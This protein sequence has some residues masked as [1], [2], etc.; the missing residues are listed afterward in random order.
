VADTGGRRG[1]V[2]RDKA[3]GTF[4]VVVDVSEVGAATRKQIKRRGFATEREAHRALTRLLTELDAGSYV[5]PDLK[6]TLRDYVENTWLPALAVRNRRPS[7]IESYKRNLRVHVFP[8]LGLR[9]LSRI[10]TPDL[11][12][13]Y[14][15]LLAGASGRRPLSPRTVRYIHTILHG[16]FQH[17][18]LKGNL[19]V[20]PCQRA[21]APEPKACRSREMKTWTAE[22]LRH[23]L[24]TLEGDRFRA[25]LLLLATTGMRRGEALGL[26]WS[27]LRLEEAELD[28]RRTLGLI[29]DRIVVG[30][31]KTDA[32]WRAVSLDDASVAALR[33]HRTEQLRERLLVGPEYCDEDWV[34]AMP[35]GR[36]MHP[37]RFTRI[38]DR[39]RAAAGL[40]RIR[41]HD[42]RHTWATLALRA[43]INPKIVQ[44]RIGHASVAITLD[45]YTHTDRQ[46]HAAAA[47][48]VSALF[49]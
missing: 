17:A 38:F 21:D 49:L 7:T 37:G 46:Q 28:I 41:L 10:T 26:K 23:F 42:L 43:G 1:S 8:R 27:D 48:A 2:R 47:A 18:V 25:P 20:N 13:L 44:E 4:Y 3:R 24:A 14:A 11:D 36:P 9:P 15:D 35:D 39:R 34:F 16:V 40:P 30:S 31:P 33:L 12:R 29:D 22:Q 5:A 6:T 32:G 45:T 19:A